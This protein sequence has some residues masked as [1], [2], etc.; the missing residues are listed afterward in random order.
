MTQINHFKFLILTRYLYI[1]CGV[2]NKTMISFDFFSSMMV[3]A[4]V[5]KL[6]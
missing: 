2:K 3:I 4:A 6:R 1:Y 5:L